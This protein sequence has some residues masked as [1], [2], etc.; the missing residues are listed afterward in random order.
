MHPP[1]GMEH[2]DIQAAGV[3][4]GTDVIRVTQTEQGK[5]DAPPLRRQV[6]P[7]GMLMGQRVKDAGESERRSVMERIGVERSFRCESRQTS[8]WS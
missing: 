8:S 4:A 5:P 2:T 6:L 1:E 3:K 7:Q